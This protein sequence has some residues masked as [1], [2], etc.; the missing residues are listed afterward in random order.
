M[1]K[2]Q[3]AWNVYRI[4]QDGSMYVVDTVFFDPDMDSHDVKSS[5]VNHDGYPSDIVVLWAW[6][7]KRH[8]S[9]GRMG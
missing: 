6:K 5:L 9:C 4:R 8:R 3:Q 1:E 2:R 7:R